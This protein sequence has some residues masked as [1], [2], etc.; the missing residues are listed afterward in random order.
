MDINK[1]LSLWDMLAKEAPA[2]SV[3]ITGVVNLKTTPVSYHKV[4]L[5]YGDLTLIVAM[6]EDYVKGLDTIRAN[7]PAWG[8]WYRPTFK[9]ISESIQTQIDYDYEKKL[10]KCLKSMNKEDNSDIGED[11]LSLAIRRG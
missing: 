5:N 6:I 7:D 4:A 1:Q 3:E 9:R 10:K 11:A 2:E 8:A